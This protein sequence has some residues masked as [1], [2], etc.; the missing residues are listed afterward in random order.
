[1]M[2]DGGQRVG[3]KALQVSL[4]AEVDPGGIDTSDLDGFV[5]EIREMM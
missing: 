1:M 4:V 3:G 5:D 2:L